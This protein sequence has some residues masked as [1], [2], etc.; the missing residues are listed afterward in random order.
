MQECRFSVYCTALTC[1]QASEQI[2]LVVDNLC[3]V[4]VADFGPLASFYPHLHVA[5]SSVNR[6]V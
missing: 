1:T 6:H 3:G 4:V 2:Q 5:I